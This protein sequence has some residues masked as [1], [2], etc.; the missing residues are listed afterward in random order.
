MVCTLGIAWRFCVVG[1][2]EHSFLW[3]GAIFVVS[4]GLS[5]RAQ[6]AEWVEGL[7]KQP[8]KACGAQYP[9][10]DRRRTFLQQEAKPALP[11]DLKKAPSF[12]WK[13][14]R[15]SASEDRRSAEDLALV[16]ISSAT[17]PIVSPRGR[18]S[19][20]VSPTSPCSP[21][22]SLRS[23][24]EDASRA[25]SPPPSAR[26]VIAA[27]L[28][29]SI[30]RSVSVGTALSSGYAAPAGQQ[31]LS[32]STGAAGATA[33]H[34]SVS[35]KPDASLQSSGS[36]AAPGLSA[37]PPVPRSAP[38][39]SPIIRLAPKTIRDRMA[40]VSVLPTT[41]FDL[42][43]TDTAINRM[44]G[45]S[46]CPVRVS[47]P[48]GQPDGADGVELPSSGHSPT[49]TRAATLSRP[50][51]SETKSK[52]RQARAAT[53][54]SSQAV[55]RDPEAESVST[56]AESD[57]TL[58]TSPPMTRARRSSRLRRLLSPSSSSSSIEHSLPAAPM[59]RMSADSSA[60]APGEFSDAAA[61]GVRRRSKTDETSDSL[62]RKSARSSDDV[63]PLLPQL[64]G[65]SENI[66]IPTDSTP[67]DTDSRSAGLSSF[68]SVESDLSNLGSFLSI[69]SDIA[70]LGDALSRGRTP[71]G[72]ARGAVGPPSAAT[73]PDLSRPKS[74][75]VLGSPSPGVVRTAPGPTSP[76]AIVSAPGPTSPRSFGAA[77]AETSAEDLPS[78]PPS[79][80]VRSRLRSMTPSSRPPP[81][82]VPASRFSPGAYE[83]KLVRNK[84]GVELGAIISFGDRPTGAPDDFADAISDALARGLESDAALTSPQL[85]T[86]GAPGDSDGANLSTEAT[87]LR[88][89]C[90]S[91]LTRLAPLEC[92]S[93]CATAASDSLLEDVPMGSLGNAAIGSRR[94]V[95]QRAESNRDLGGVSGLLSL[96]AA[97]I[98]GLFEPVSVVGRKSDAGYVGPDV[99]AVDTMASSVSLEPCER[100]S[101]E[102]ESRVGDDRSAELSASIGEMASAEGS[103]VVAPTGEAAGAS[104][105][106]TIGSPER[107]SPRSY[108]KF[109]LTSLPAHSLFPSRSPDR[110]GTG[111][112][113][114]RTASAWSTEPD[115]DRLQ[116]LASP[117]DDITAALATS[118]KTFALAWNP[119]RVS[120]S[121]DGS[122][123]ADITAALL[124][125]SPKTFAL[126]WN[127]RRV[128]SSFDGSEVVVPRS[129]TISSSAPARGFF[130]AEIGAARKL[131]LS[132]SASTPAFD[133]AQLEQ[134]PPPALSDG[135]KRTSRGE[136]V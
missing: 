114:E 98:E 58:S 43:V 77:L 67:T 86:S 99:S 70:A 48:E 94:S 28:P 111:S 62:A 76:R 5:W 117:A 80:D 133:A 16:D 66:S 12:S 82:S 19:G 124:A 108:G 4:P 125:T 54:D 15:A 18:L 44:R 17:S 32:Q 72:S 8:A 126:A 53:L 110:S 6:T 13:K 27:I 136:T 7:F 33:R 91:N 102:I 129:G 59:R 83:R 112:Q 79:Q 130:Q 87:Q 90:D 55:M 23:S 104:L 95:V 36:T 26:Q 118:P 50:T 132:K 97:D 100:S 128:S 71:S 9:S 52:R 14:L 68:S 11:I 103:S 3:S 105:V 106:P 39:T 60:R 61:V 64:A 122:E 49:M 37:S 20:T 92:D 46:E 30:Q 115:A 63:D 42:D 89:V 134:G 69:A 119:R 78:S 45:Q 2:R 88:D 85:L 135:K 65:L 116:S 41:E 107:V 74:D 51:R 24:V 121:S 127:P 40:S 34:P 81:S 22:G 1:M 29:R 113:H 57:L 96:P 10:A 56:S 131:S 25:V 47:S 35:P 123:P 109:G 21:S 120:A 75:A 73:S 101:T 93:N 31:Q 38:K 84:S